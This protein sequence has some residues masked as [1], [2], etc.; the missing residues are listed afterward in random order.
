M[1]AANIRCYVFG[2]TEVN[3]KT[4]PDL[5]AYRSNVSR[6]TW[7]SVMLVLPEAGWPPV[8]VPGVL[9]SSSVSSLPKKQMESLAGHKIASCFLSN[10]FV[11]PDMSK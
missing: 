8:Y 9:C 10:V 3:M 11:A 1:E 6:Y 5:E 7:L 2:V 4:I